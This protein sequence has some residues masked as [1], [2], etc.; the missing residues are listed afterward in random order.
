MKVN[1]C[2]ILNFQYNSK[3]ILWYMELIDTH[4]M[5]ESFLS[6]FKHESI[7]CC[8]RNYVSG[9][10]KIVP[11]LVGWLG[12]LGWLADKPDYP[13]SDTVSHELSSDLHLL[14]V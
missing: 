2:L 8:T 4:A 11:W 10:S 9:H 12:E 1:E 5:S 3:I 14:H 13:H 6:N 7:H